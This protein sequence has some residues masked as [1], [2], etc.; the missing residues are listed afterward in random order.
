[1]SCAKNCRGLS[2][3]LVES[4]NVS[5]KEC[6]QKDSEGCWIKFRLQQQFG[7]NR[8]KAEILKHRG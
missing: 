2:H 3:T 6:Q 1:M 7:V 8:Y 5:G 4:F